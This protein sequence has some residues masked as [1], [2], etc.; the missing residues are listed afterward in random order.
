MPAAYYDDDGNRVKQC[1]K[2]KKVL[3]VEEYY[4]HAEG[5]TADGLQPRCRH[6]TLAKYRE[7][8]R[9]RAK[10]RKQKSHKLN[11][12]HVDWIKEQKGKLSI[13]ETARQFSKK[14][15]AYKINPSTVQRIFAGKI[16]VDA[17]E[18]DTISIYDLLAGASDLTGSVED[19]VESLDPKK[20]KL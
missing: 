1:T 10:K 11:K 3:P 17:G 7:Q 2:C 12:L 8:N 6:C 9:R 4:K 13:R 20:V 18:Q 16:H 19:Y 15:F 5:V 14:F